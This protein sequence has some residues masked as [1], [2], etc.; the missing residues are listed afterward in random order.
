[1]GAYLERSIPERSRSERGQTLVLF[2]FALA[3]LMGIAALTVDVGLAF[4]ARRDVQNAADSAV[5][6]G[7]SLLM[8]GA[9]PMVVAAEAQAWA[10]KNGYSDGVDNVS[11]AVN[12]PPTSGPHAGDSNFI[13]VV[14]EQEVDAFLATVLG[15][16]IW[17]VAARAVAGIDRQPQPYAIIALNETACSAY[18]HSGSGDVTING[19]GIMANSNCSDGFRKVGSGDVTADVIDYYQEGGYSISG[20]GDVTPTPSLV[21]DRVDD[22]LAGLVPPA[23]GAPA[24]GS[25]GTAESPQLTHLTGSDDKELFPG[26]YYG[27]IKISGSG[28]V[29]FHSGIYVIAGGGLDL[30]SSGNKSG[31]DVMFYNTNDPVQPTGAGAFGAFKITGS[32]NIQFSAFSSEPYANMLFWQDPANTL[33]ADKSGSGNLTQG[34]IYLP[35]ARLDESGS[36]NMGATQIVVDG[37]DKSGSGNVVMTSGGWVGE[38]SGPAVRLAE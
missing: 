30:G 6:A 2:V 19:G 28:D 8:E 14:V 12:V 35:T 29:I 16:D 38:S 17:D 18:D 11:V 27:G 4:V 10:E 33:D 5:L 20:S 26:T 3:A 24:Q 13:E 23:P 7:A 25:A 32:G 9:P 31:S 22:P 34:I 1:M 21:D 15:K 37:Y 36:G